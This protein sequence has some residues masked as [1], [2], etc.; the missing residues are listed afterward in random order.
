MMRKALLEDGTDITSLVQT[1]YDTAVGSM[2][3]NSGFLSTE[4]A[5]ELKMLA[6][7]MGFDV[8][9]Y[10]K[11]VCATCGHAYERHRSY[12]GVSSCWASPD[13]GY[14]RHNEDDACGCTGF[15]STI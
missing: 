8:V 2:N 1:A 15:E 13:G 12:K 7:F 4:K 10:S 3:F 14:R 11:D 9:N 5:D 6:R